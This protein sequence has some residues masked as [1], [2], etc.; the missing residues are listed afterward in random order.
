M[1]ACGVQWT[2]GLLHLAFLDAPSGLPVCQGGEK[3]GN[4]ARGA[5]YEPEP[6]GTAPDSAQRDRHRKTPLEEPGWPYEYDP[7]NKYQ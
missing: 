6:Q 5:G 1:D 4:E 7:R 3:G 2:L